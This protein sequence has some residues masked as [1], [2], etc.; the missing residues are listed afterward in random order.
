MVM[1]ELKD[2]N[3]ALGFFCNPLVDLITWV[4]FTIL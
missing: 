2:E 1:I 3:F 4:K